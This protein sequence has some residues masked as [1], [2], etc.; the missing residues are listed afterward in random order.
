M[1]DGT[2]V[3]EL[4]ATKGLLRAKNSRVESEVDEWRVDDEGIAF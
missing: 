2:R 4:A 1:G 3:R